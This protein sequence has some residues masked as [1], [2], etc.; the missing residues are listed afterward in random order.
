LLPPPSGKNTGPSVMKMPYE[1][2]K[3]HV[4]KWVGIWVKETAE[5]LLST[6]QKDQKD[7]ADKA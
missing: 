7:P 4:I 6:R 1:D 2:V 5:S 3:F